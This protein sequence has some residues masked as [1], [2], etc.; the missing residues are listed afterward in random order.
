MK[1]LGISGSARAASTNTALLQA[2]ARAASEDTGILAKVDVW[3]GVA[4]LPV[5]SPD[6]EG[7]KTPPEVLHFANRIATADALVVACPEYVHALP[8]G[9]KNA[10][11][12]LVSR[13]EIIGK[14]IALLHASHRGADVLADLRRVLATVSDGFRPEI[15]L[16][17]P[18]GK[19]SPDEVRQHCATPDLTRQLTDFLT[20]LSK[21]IALSRPD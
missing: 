15:F 20:T 6:R 5:F 18:C 9:F 14:P 11:D 17:I 8:G 1:V 21:E 4:D 13:Q 2:L 10:I 16:Q 3:A 12:W 7:D 19:M